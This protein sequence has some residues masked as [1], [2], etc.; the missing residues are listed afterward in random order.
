[1]S[2]RGQADRA[3]GLDLTNPLSAALQQF[4]IGKF[5]DHVKDVLTM[6]WKLYQRMGPD[7]IFFQVTGNPNPQVMTK[8]SADENFSIMVSFDSLASDPE[9]AETQLKNMVSLTQLDRN[10]ILD[11]NKLLEFAASSINP[12][13]ADYVLQPV[14][15]AQQKVQKNV[16]DDLAKIF[17]GIEVPA[18][19]NGA[20]IAMQMVQAYVQQPDVAARAQQDEAFAARLQKYA[21]QYQFQLQQAQNAEIGR[22]GTAPAE[23][24]GMTTQGM[25]Q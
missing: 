12:I 20:Q 11:I 6:A 24:G 18:Q 5:L 15:E 2:M 22:I 16:T 25:E 8:G 1:M 21:S 4:F 23:M 9:T 3:V 19:P 10:G 7:E 14:E 13:F 17:A